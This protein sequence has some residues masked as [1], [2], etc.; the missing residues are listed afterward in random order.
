M[1]LWSC[2]AAGAAWADPPREARI[3]AVLVLR[4]LKF[5]DW[6]PENALRMSESLQ[7]CTWGESPT[8][9]ALQSLQGQKIRDRE[10][11]VR[12][13]STPLDTRG[14]H[15]LFVSEMVRDVTPAQL[16]NSGS[17]AVLTISDMPDFNKRGGIINLV[18]QEN[19]IGFEIQLRYARE[20]RL[21]IGSP[22]LDL[23]RVVD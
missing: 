8:E 13:V 22:L 11:R 12:K 21:Q 7:I 20:Q 1:V 23:A 14:C 6:P 17:A 3:K 4:L 10:V 2:L 5:V 19:R 18:R 9:A 16:Y 15:V